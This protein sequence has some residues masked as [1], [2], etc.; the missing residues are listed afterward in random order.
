MRR[1]VWLVLFAGFLVLTACPN[2]TNPPPAAPRG[3]P[4]VMGEQKS[5][6]RFCD[7][8]F[9]LV[10]TY[11]S[12]I[13]DIDVTPSIAGANTFATIASSPATAFTLKAG[14]ETDVTITGKLREC[15]AGLGQLQLGPEV[16]P[17]NVTI[18]ALPF[19]TISPPNATARSDGSYS[20]TLQVVCCPPDIPGEKRSV[21]ISVGTG[22][23]APVGTITPNRLECPTDGTKTVTVTGRLT[24]APDR[25]SRI[26]ITETTPT[27]VTCRL[28]TTIS[29]P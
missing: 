16:A 6:D 28:T 8:T 17:F 21:T 11:R 15:M 20:Y 9:K 23:G 18:P 13:S 12:A 1:T 5:F 2:P 29:P 19:R 3:A 22:G 26:I 24:E 25:D 27:T 7:G 14:V 4:L 10:I